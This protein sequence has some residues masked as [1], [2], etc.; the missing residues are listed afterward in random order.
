MVERTLRSLALTLFASPAFHPLTWSRPLKSCN[1]YGMNVTQIRF[2]TDSPREVGNNNKTQCA[3]E[4]LFGTRAKIRILDCRRFLS[5]YIAA[6]NRTDGVHIRWR[7]SMEKKNFC[8]F[9]FW[10]PFVRRR[11]NSGEKQCAFPLPRRPSCVSIAWTRRTRD[12]CVRIGT[13]GGMGD[14]GERTKREI[15]G[16]RRDYA[17]ADT[18]RQ[19]PCV[20]SHRPARRTRIYFNL[21]QGFGNVLVCDTYRIFR[22]S[23]RCGHRGEPR[24]APPSRAEMNSRKRGRVKN[25]YWTFCIHN[26][27][28]RREF[29]NAYNTWVLYIF[30][31]H[32][33]ERKPLSE[34]TDLHVLRI[35]SRTSRT[36]NTSK[37]NASSRR[38]LNVQ[39]RTYIV[40]G[41][42]KYNKKNYVPLQ[43]DTLLLK[44]N[45]FF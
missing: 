18:R 37:R 25:R 13:T 44:C 45:F 38:R 24:F 34:K 15:R 42:Q 9:F 36:W 16:R 20:T 6:A 14:G 41:N 10:Q 31:P 3:A 26:N 22:S 5:Y 4:G 35:K 2:E 29:R 19:S 17:S 28:E 39:S 12:G 7:R 21:L 1:P 8:F 40:I 23:S 33:I 43:Y 11:L 27:S 30:N 32:I